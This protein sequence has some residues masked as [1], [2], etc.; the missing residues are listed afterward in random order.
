MTKIMK[1]LKPYWLSIVL[2]LGLLFGQATCELT[3]PDY[4]Q[5]IVN[6]GIQNGGIESGVYEQVR[7]ST[8]NSYVMFATDSE[9]DLMTSSYK[10]VTP[11]KATKEEKTKNSSFENR[12]CISIKK[13]LVKKKEEKAFFHF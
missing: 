10:L 7:E 1:Y 11:S 5:N 3:M 12:E 8:F 13:I 2:A 4:M 9:K 6:T